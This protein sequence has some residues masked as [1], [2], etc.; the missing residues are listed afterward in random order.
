MMF[1]NEKNKLLKQ[2]LDSF[3]LKIYFKSFFQLD[4]IQEKVKIEAQTI[5]TKTKELLEDWSTKKPI[6]VCRDFFLRKKSNRSFYQGDLKPRD[7]IRQLAQYET[8]LNEQLEKRTTLNKAKQSVKMQES[9]T[10]IYLD[11]NRI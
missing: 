4:T 9:S 10:L 8:K 11:F 3:F 7:A 1:L 2:K 5:D 6:G